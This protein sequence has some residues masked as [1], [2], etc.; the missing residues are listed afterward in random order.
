MSG[1]GIH[2]LR[3]WQEARNLV[4]MVY[5]VTASLPAGEN[6]NMIPQMRRAATS[7]MSNIAEGHGRYYKKEFIRF[8]YIARGS[9]TELQSLSVL[10][11]D[12]N[13]LSQEEKTRLR[14]GI[15]VV[16]PMLNGLIESLVESLVKED[17]VD[18]YVSTNNEERT[19]N[20]DH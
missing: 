7:V 18:L 10:T 11:S 5:E 15:G 6:Y 9:L 2:D 20:N 16:G 14:A 19:T 12:L 17:G 8:L 1:Q 13:Y 3:V 4:R